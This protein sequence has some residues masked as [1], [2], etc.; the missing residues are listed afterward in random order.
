MIRRP[1]PLLTGD[2]RA[3]VRPNLADVIE[4][5]KS[6]LSMNWIIGSPTTARL[7]AVGRVAG[8]AAALSKPGE[9][10]VAM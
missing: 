10:R 6:G 9:Q 2:Q 7:G 5:R 4:Y 1:L 8:E 3:R